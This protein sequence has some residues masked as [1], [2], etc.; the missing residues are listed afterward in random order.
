MY[1]FEVLIPK[2]KVP[3]L[4]YQSN[5]NYQIGD[6]VTVPFRHQEITGIIWQKMQKDPQIPLKNIIQND[7]FSASINC[8]LMKFIEKAQRYY[9]ADLGSIAKLVLPVNINE[10]PIKIFK[11]DVSLHHKL[12]TLSDKQEECLKAIEKITK[13]LVIKGV[14]GSGKT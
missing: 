10:K 5:K 7:N 8:N 3:L 14:T 4:H 1:I 12:A 9:L 6:L 2:I 11:Q 13:P